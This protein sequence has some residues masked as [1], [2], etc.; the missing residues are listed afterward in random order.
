LVTAGADA[1]QDDI[2]DGATYKQYSQTEKTKL[3]GIEAAADVTDAANVAAAG[4]VMDTGNETVAG[5][6]T[7]SSSPVV[8]TPATDFQAATKKYVDDNAGGIVAWGDITGDPADQTDLQEALNDKLNQSDIIDEDDFS[9][10]SSIKVPTQQ[11]VKAYVDG[12]TSPIQTEIDSKAPLASPTFTGTVTVPTPINGTDAA[13]KTYVDGQSGTTIMDAWRKRP[14]LMSDFLA[15]NTGTVDPF[16]GLAIS[17]GTVNSPNAG[18]ITSNHLGV[19]RLR[20]STSANSGAFVGSNT[21]QLLLGGNEVYEAIFNITTLTNGTF[22]LGFHDTATSADATDGAYIEIDSAGVAFGK[23]ATNST[24][25]STGTTYT[26]ATATWYRARI[27][28]NSNASQVDFYL[29]NDGG[30]LL[31]TNN[32]TANIPTAAGRETGAGFI[33]TNSGTTA[34]DLVHLDYMALAWG[35]DRVR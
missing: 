10:D 5:I 25:S 26:V 16:L 35:S 11:S 30:T 19:I 1:T 32:L 22:R 17:S 12:V 29:Y 20:S 28:V 6:K 23:T 31:W 14:F 34:T 2:G 27:V 33:A 3:A 24:R 4:A 8:P 13:T 9:S 7:F 15:A 18:I 21:G